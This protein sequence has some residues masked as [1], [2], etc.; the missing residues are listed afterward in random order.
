[1]GDRVGSLIRTGVMIVF[2][3]WSEGSRGGM[4][5]SFSIPARAEDI[6]CCGSAEGWRPCNSVSI[7]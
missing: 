4:P 7:R 3:V 2:C 1:V 6:E 5:R